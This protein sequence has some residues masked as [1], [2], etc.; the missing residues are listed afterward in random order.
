MD[1]KNIID[2]SSQT[3]VCVCSYRFCDLTPDSSNMYFV[4]SPTQA[5]KLVPKNDFVINLQKF[6]EATQ[7]S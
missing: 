3:K 6:V 2:N 4:A 7:E 1:S 5:Y